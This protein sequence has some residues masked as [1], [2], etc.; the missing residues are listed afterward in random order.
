MKGVLWKKEEIEILEKY[1]PI[2]S[3]QD[4]LSLLPNRPLNGIVSQACRIGIKRKERF[5]TKKA[6]KLLNSRGYWVIPL[7]ILTVE[8]KKL[9][10]KMAQKGN[11]C[12][13]VLEHR[14]EIAKKL[15]RPLT[16]YEIVHHKNGI[17]SDNRLEN[18]ELMTKNTHPP[19]YTTTCPNCGFK[20]NF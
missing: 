18:L 2:K 19:G 20:F 15:G 5:R 17:K 3:N 13:Y 4:I 14:L 1:Y 8:D 10:E 16:A 6:K 7:S 12:K 11:R 9:A